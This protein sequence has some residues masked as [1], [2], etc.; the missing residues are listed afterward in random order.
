MIS[1]RRKMMYELGDKVKIKTTNPQMVGEVVLW[2]Y[3]EGN[4][5]TVELSDGR[6]EDFEDH[7]LSPASDAYGHTWA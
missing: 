7:D 3:D 2:H 5:W 1:T 6:W 4:V